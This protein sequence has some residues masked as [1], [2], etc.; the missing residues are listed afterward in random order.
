MLEQQAIIIK[1]NQEK[2]EDE[3]MKTDTSCMDPIS[4]VY[5]QNRKLEIMTKRGFNL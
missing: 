4:T 1:Q 3:F 2:Q 5:F